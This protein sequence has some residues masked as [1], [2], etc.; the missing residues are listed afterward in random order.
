MKTDTTIT[1]RKDEHIKVNLSND[2][3]SHRTT[4]L[5][6]LAFIHEALPEINL[7]DID[8]SSKLFGKKI[9]APIL[10]SSMTGGTELSRQINQRL[11]KVANEF[12]I[13]MGVGSQRAG[14]ENPD[15]S[16]SF[17]VIRKTAPN[18]LL[19]A[20]LGAIQL[21]NGY[22]LDHCKRAI[23][24]IGADGLILHLNP[25]QESLQEEGNTNFAFLSKNIESICKNLTIP[26]IVKEVGWGISKRT[27][28]ILWDSG[29]S[30][31]DVA[32]AGGTSWSQVEMYRSKKE[33]SRQLALT[34]YEWGI[35]TVDSIKNVLVSAP[36]MKIIASGGLQSGL[37][38]TKCI[39]LGAIL[40]GMA[41][42]FLQASSASTDRL[43]E[44]IQLTIEQIR[45]S[46]FCTGAS[47]LSKL[48]AS[49]LVVI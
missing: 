49:Q 6:R 40:G 26:V 23:D 33:I 34:F 37:D 47:S 39:A 10:I 41:G 15:T 9:S 25:L 36:G 46:M 28:K 43:R 20:N 45:I 31:I 13:A 16:P 1:Q 27:A 22:T 4:G 2:V 29:V 3:K 19:F 48:S 7:C 30:V 17:S 32:G 24:M 11:A 38:I 18:I 21:N 44:L 42:M 12:N 14:L 8:L 5:E 35:P